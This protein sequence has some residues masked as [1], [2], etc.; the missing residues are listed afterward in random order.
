VLR[1]AQLARAEF[2]NAVRRRIDDPKLASLVIRDVAVSD[3]LSVVDIS[4]RFVG[5]EAEAE[6]TRLFGRLKRAMPRLTR[7]VVPRLEL[8]RAPELRVHLDTGED[9]AQRVAELLREIEEESKPK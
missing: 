6:R 9:A 8:R 7:E 5:V 3:D 4:V 1:V 2:A